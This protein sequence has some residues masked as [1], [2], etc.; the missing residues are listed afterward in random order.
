MEGGNP[1]FQEERLIAI[2]QYLKNHKRISVEEICDLYE[3]SRDTARRDM[4]K[5]EESGQIIRTS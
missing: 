5:L 2:V 4:V 3:V 1:I